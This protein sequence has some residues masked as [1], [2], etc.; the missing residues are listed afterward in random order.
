M[1]R[2]LT[3][4]FVASVLLTVCATVPR[5]QTQTQPAQTPVPPIKLAR[6]PDYHAGRLAFTYL[7]DIWTAAENGG[8]PD[9][10]TDHIGHDMSPKFS[11]DGKWI[12]FASNRYGS[13][14][15]FVVP[16][17]GGTATRLTFHPGGDDVVGWTRDSTKVLIRSAR[18]AGAFP[19]VATLWEVPVAGGPEVAL[20]LDW[21]A[22][23]SY[24]PD[25]RSL[26]FNRHPSSWT[27]QHYRSFAAADLWIANL[28]AKTFTQLL[29]NERYNRLW[30]MWGTDNMIYF[31]ADPLPNDSKVIPGSPDIRKSANNIYKI[32][33][34]GGQPVQVTHHPDGNLFWPS[35]SS[36]G[37]VIVYE[38]MF[39]LWK[40]DVASGRTSEIR[41]SIASDDKAN[42]SDL[43]VVRIHLPT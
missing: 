38:S 2:R 33:P 12:A 39:G 17:G 19:N 28:A 21:G 40:L 42:E 25:G 23:G 20:P 4:A 18:N 26:A 31:V 27:R 37:K 11:P 15:V 16:S 1:T 30:P 29:P 10:I 41:I 8:D 35:M 22:Y 14:D 43:E 9:R 13:N 32:S 3:L 36:D 6:Q 7:G 24:S 5:G 34:T